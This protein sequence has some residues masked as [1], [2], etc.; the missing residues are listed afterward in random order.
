VNSEFVHMGEG[1]FGIRDGVY[2]GY[3]KGGM[4]AR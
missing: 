3:G 2:M 1:V 4:S